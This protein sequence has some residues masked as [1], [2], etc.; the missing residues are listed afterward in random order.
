MRTSIKYVLA[1]FALVAILG[2]SLTLIDGAEARTC[3]WDGG[4]AASA[5]A[6]DPD[7][8]DTDTA[9]IA[10]DDIL[11]DG[12]N[13]SAD[14]PCTWDLAT[15]SF[16][17]FTIAAEYSGTI[18]Q[19]SDMYISGYSQAGGTF[20]GDVTKWVYCDGS[21]LKSAGTFTIYKTRF[22]LLGTGTFSSIHP[23][24]LIVNGIYSFITD[25]ITIQGGPLTITENS[26]LTIK[27]K[28]INIRRLI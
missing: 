12:L 1:F 20:T 22:N 14:D 3:V 28:V 7:N 18:T 2:L 5:L 17:N 19:S 27:V 15:N 10:G 24:S 13:A 26:I 9:P 21:V 11:F 25:G 8:W 23:H 6:S 4:D 16:G